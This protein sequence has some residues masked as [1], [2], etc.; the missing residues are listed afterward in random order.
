MYFYLAILFPFSN[1]QVWPVISTNMLRLLQPHHRRSVY[2]HC[3]HL[4]WIPSWDC[5][6]GRFNFS[7][8]F[9]CFNV[10]LQCLR[11]TMHR[12]WYHHV[13]SSLVVLQETPILR[14]R[15]K[16][17]TS[18]TSQ[19]PWQKKKWQCTYKPRS[20]F[21]PLLHDPNVKLNEWKL[22]P[23]FWSQSRHME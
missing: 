18:R 12:R 1:Q 19:G 10:Y 5:N 7:F 16:V 14:S 21:R 2:N 4:G 6:S 23:P 13:G 8:S 20:W 11:P 22:D 9:F 15:C 17:V 3:R